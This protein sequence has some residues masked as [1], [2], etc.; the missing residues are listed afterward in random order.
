MSEPTRDT[1]ILTSDLVRTF[2]DVKAVDGIDLAVTRGEIFGFLGPNGAG[3]STTVR[4]LTTL[5]KPTSG[6][7]HVAGFNVL[8]NAD[9][10]RRSIGVALQD[11]AIDPLM[12]GRELLRLQAVL[13]AIDKKR[14]PRARRRS[15]GEGR[16]R[17]GRRPA[18][19]DLLRRYAPTPRPC[20]GSR[21]RSDSAVPRRAHDRTRPE[22]S[23]R[24]LG[25]G[26]QAQHARRARR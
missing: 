25:R 14:A 2:G 16:A 8:T 3:K 15:I 23:R 18:R 5:L 12:T 13:H 1:P 26:A 11:A 21:T 9:D 6:S 20:A 4:M 17:S 24:D 10:V 22:Q 7:A 19:G